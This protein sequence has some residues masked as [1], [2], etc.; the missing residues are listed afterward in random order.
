MREHMDKHLV[1]LYEVKRQ[2]FLLGYLQHP[3]LYSK[4]H[5]FAVLNRLAP[6][7]HE[8]IAREI[9]GA[10][11]FEDVHAVKADFISSVLKYVDE[12]WH[13]KDFDALGFYKLE[14][15]FGGYKV[16]RIEL[17]HSLG[18]IRI[19]GRFDD[20]VWSAVEANAPSEAKPINSTF[21]PSD[22]YFD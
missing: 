2:S 14:E 18:Y 7:F 9:H 22:V 20:A 19:D 3:N 16:N 17:I 12:R 4:A 11:P 5:A 6:I 8:N 21:S 13:A 15:K 1:A 10:D